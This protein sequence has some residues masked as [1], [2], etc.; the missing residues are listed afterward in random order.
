MAASNYG[1]D[2][3]TLVA[4]ALAPVSEIPRSSA[5]GSAGGIGSQDVGIWTGTYRGIPNRYKMGSPF[6]RFGRRKDKKNLAHHFSSSK[7]IQRRR[8]RRGR[9]QRPPSLLS[10]EDLS[11]VIICIATAAGGERDGGEKLDTP[12]TTTIWPDDEIWTGNKCAGHMT[13]SKTCGA[14]SNKYDLECCPGLSCDGK[15]CIGTVVTAGEDENDDDQRI[16]MTEDTVTTNNETDTIEL[17]TT[18]IQREANHTATM[19]KLELA[20]Q[21]MAKKRKEEE[22]RRRKQAEEQERARQRAADEERRRREELQRQEEAKARRPMEKKALIRLYED[23][24]GDK[25][26]RSGGWLS[27]DVDQ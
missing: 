13:K 21:E 17:N 7:M 24:N 22:E 26:N 1:G 9:Q 5:F 3:P 18:T 25:W 10:I 14:N 16:P 11:L 27:D 23:T 4:P 15:F 19:Q 8:R 2:V 6:S 20:R 12:A